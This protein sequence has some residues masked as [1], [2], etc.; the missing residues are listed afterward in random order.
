MEAWHKREIEQREFLEKLHR[1]LVDDGGGDYL[2][3]DDILQI[4]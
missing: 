3:D 4:A 1:K 2:D